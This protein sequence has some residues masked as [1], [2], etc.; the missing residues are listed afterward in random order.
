MSIQ[1]TQRLSSK[2][3]RFPNRIREYR[4]K[5]GLT[6]TALGRLVGKGRK[7]VSAWE[8]VVRLPTVANALKLARGLATLVEGYWESLYSP[9]RARA[10]RRRPSR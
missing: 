10:P 3:P 7:I 6:Q 9:Q 2:R 1:L 4:L 5:S 8:R